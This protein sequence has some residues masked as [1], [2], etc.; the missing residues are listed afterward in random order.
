[1]LV[2]MNGRGPSI[3]RSTCVSAAR[4]STAVGRCAANTLAT[5]HGIGDVGLHERHARVVQRAVEIQQAAGIRQLVEDDEAVGGVCERV[6]NE[7]G[8]DE[9]GSA[10]DEKSAHETATPRNPRKKKRHEKHERKTMTFREFRAFACFVVI[11]KL[12]PDTS[13]PGAAPWPANRPS[14]PS[15]SRRLRSRSAGRRCGGPT[16]RSPVRWRG[17]PNGR[18]APDPGA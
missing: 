15:A 3:E 10:G 7:I 1:M 2:S 6:V 8:A 16:A 11:R 18:H 13:A 14:S 9:P 12:L 5:A 17:S 4:L